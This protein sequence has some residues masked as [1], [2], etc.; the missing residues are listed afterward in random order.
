MDSS[1]HAH[2]H[3][4]KAVVTIID[5]SSS[6]WLH[7]PPMSSGK[8]QGCQVWFHLLIELCHHLCSLYC[9]I[10]YVFL[11]FDSYPWWILCGMCNYPSA[12]AFTLTCLFSYVSPFKSLCAYTYTSCIC[13]QKAVSFLEQVV[14]MGSH[15]SFGKLQDTF[16]VNKEMLTPDDHLVIYLT[17]VTRGPRQFS[18]RLHPIKQS[19]SVW[20]W[21]TA[22]GHQSSAST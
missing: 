14:K 20:H 3:K 22:L 4:S 12:L 10:T 1:S 6:F 2:A 5:I 7:I 19:R 18:R 21:K 17:A 15:F 8:C 9:S 11:I 16:V 13:K